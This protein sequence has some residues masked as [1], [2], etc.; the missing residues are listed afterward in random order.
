MSIY[1]V[2]ECSYCGDENK[3]LRPSPFMADTGA[4]M[5]EDCWNMTREEYKNSTGEFIPDFQDNKED[6]EETKNNMNQKIEN[7]VKNIVIKYDDGT[8]REISKGAIIEYNSDGE[9]ANLEFEFKDCG[10]NDLSNIIYGILQM[11]AQ[12]GLFNDSESEVEQ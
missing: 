3:V 2:G 6:Y 5:C 7:N 4:M 9:K 11:A 1:E 8:E 12:M 10:G